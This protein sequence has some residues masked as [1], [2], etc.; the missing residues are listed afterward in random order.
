MSRPLTLSAVVLQ[1]LTQCQDNV[2]ISQ[3]SHLDC[4][5]LNIVPESLQLCSKEVDW[6]Y[7]YLADSTS[8]LSS[9]RSKD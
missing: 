3:H 5:Q 4:V 6:W 1:L 2:S 8:I 9:E 7:V